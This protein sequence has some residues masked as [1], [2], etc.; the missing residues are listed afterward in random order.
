ML[1]MNYQATPCYIPQ[2]F[3]ILNVQNFK[4]IDSLILNFFIE[5]FRKVVWREIQTD[6]QRVATRF[7]SSHRPP[8]TL[9][10][11]RSDTA[12]SPVLPT[13]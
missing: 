11:Y 5:N 10:K 6:R 3:K 8:R 1:V 9:L 7:G 13:A 2:M 12:C 4:I